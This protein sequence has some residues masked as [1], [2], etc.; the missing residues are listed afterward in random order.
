MKKIK[1]LKIIEYGLYLLVFLLP[2][3]TRLFLHKGVLNGGYFE[4][5]TISLYLTDVILLFLVL[6]F[7]IFKF[8][9]NK[10]SDN[11]LEIP[12]YWWI[13]S[14]LELTIF[15]SIFAAE[16][17][18]IALFKYIQFLMAIGLFWLV[19]SA[20]Y[21]KRNLLFC[22]ISGAF[23]QSLLGIW[24][25][26]SQSTFSN[27]W[28][29]VAAHNPSDLGVSVVETLDDGRWLRSYGGLDHPNVLGGFLVVAII[30]GLVLLYNN[31]LVQSEIN[32]TN[33]K[34]KEQ[35]KISKNKI[36]SSLIIIFLSALFCALFFTFSRGAWAGLILAF[37]SILFIAL[38]KKDFA[39]IKFFLPIIFIFTI[40][41]IILFN[42]YQEL[43]LTRLSQDTR[44]EVMSTTERLESI[45]ISQKIIK[46]HWLLGA[47][48][49]NYNNALYAEINSKQPSFYYQPVHNTYLLIWAEIGI[50]G[51]L[52]FCSML[53]YIFYLF[54]NSS[55]KICNYFYVSIFISSVVMMIFDHWWWS[56]HF[57]VLLNWFILGLIFKNKE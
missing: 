5:G 11:E 9:T 8:K 51:L 10:K 26:L 49:G 13:I 42:Q 31:Y 20:E 50:I 41:S 24:Q 15:I 32:K 23:A 29:G 47:G 17:M 46:E 57:G 53:F 6:I 44:L 18:T 55:F 56:G 1:V 38:A 14:F 37:L 54:K 2:L 19:I 40:I 22:F 7:S 45:G 28:L 16:N 43:V 4:Y 25:F 12:I 33:F 48:I 39:I 21:K 30:I 34:I 27:K 35:L 3:Q 36:S 52:A